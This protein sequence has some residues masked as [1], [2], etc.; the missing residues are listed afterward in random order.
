MRAITWN[1]LRQAT[2]Q[3]KPASLRYVGCKIKVRALVHAVP[4]QWREM[5]N[6]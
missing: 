2:R 1:A 6:Q 5:K 4:V 3:V